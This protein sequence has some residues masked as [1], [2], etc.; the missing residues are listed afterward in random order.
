MRISLDQPEIEQAIR[1]YLAGK[2]IT[3]ADPNY[4]IEFTQRR[5]PSTQ[6]TAEIDFGSP[7]DAAPEPETA[8]RTRRPRKPV[9]EQTTPEPLPPGWGDPA[10]TLVLKT[11]GEPMTQEETNELVDAVANTAAAQGLFSAPTPTA[12]TEVPPPDANG[13]ISLFG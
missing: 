10:E 8:T 12:E 3:F 9:V 1:E 13:K 6:I 7:A 11:D 2:G 4:P 5:L